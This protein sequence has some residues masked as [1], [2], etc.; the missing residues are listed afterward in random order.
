MKHLRINVGCGQA[1]TKGWRNFDNSPSLRLAKIPML[2]S[3]LAGAGLLD[4]GQRGYIEFARRHAIEFGDVVRGLPLPEASVEVLYSAHMLEHLDRSGAD[5]FLREAMRVLVPGGLI[6]LCVPD[7]KKLCA[8]Y[9]ATGDADG[10]LDASMLCAPAPASFR[11]RLRHLLVGPRHHQWMY[12]GQSLQLLLARRGFRD[13]AIL[14]PG[15]TSIIDP[16]ALDLRDKA[17]ESVYV[18]ARKPA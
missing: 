15:E 10:F 16:G 8:R 12:D 1:P 4:G 3:L 7:I 13:T 2:P 9:A 11:A 5:R 18:E 14:P 6:R 17:D